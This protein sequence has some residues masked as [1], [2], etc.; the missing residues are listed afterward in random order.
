MSTI[1]FN[2]AIFAQEALTAFVANCPALNLFS[3]SY[4]S[5]AAQKGNAIYVPRVDALTATTFNYTDNSGFPYEQ[6]GGTINTITVTLDQQ[7]ICPCDLTDLQAVP[8]AAE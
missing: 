1:N 2:D 4:N 3:H 5:E 7:F 8:S 6:T